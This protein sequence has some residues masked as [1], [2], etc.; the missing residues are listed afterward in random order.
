MQYHVNVI[1]LTDHLHI[2]CRQC[3][4]IDNIHCLYFYIIKWMPGHSFIF[5]QVFGVNCHSE[6]GVLNNQCLRLFRCFPSGWC[7]QGA[8]L[9]LQG[10]AAHTPCAG[11]STGQAAGQVPSQGGVFSVEDRGGVTPTACR[12]LRAGTKLWLNGAAGHSYTLQ[13]LYDPRY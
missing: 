2:M 6:K 13:H 10:R 11:L 3:F 8:G 1:K 5:V 4:D 9:L 12:E 7:Q